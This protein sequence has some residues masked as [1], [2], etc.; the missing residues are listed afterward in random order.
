VDSIEKK[1]GFPGEEVLRALKGKGGERGLGGHS[2]FK[3]LK[4]SIPSRVAFFSWF[5]LRNFR[6]GFD[7]R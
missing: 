1:R 6:E 5:L 2:L 7:N 4:V 3:Y